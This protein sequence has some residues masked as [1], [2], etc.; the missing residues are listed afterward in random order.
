MV[1]LWMWVY[2]K[3][4]IINDYFSFQSGSD[5]ATEPVLKSARPS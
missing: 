2:V 4:I 5:V 1:L 3:F